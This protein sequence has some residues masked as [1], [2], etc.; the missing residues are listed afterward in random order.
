MSKYWFFLSYAR[1]NDL[2]SGR[3]GD[4]KDRRLIQRFYQDLVREMISRGLASIPRT[5]TEVGFFDQGGIEPGDIWDETLAKALRTSRVLV[6]LYSRGYFESEYCGKEFQVF[7]SRVRDYSITRN[8]THLPLIIPVLWHRPDKFPSLPACTSDI[9]YAHDEFGSVYAVE[10]L[11]YI[12]RLQKCK[13]NYEEFLIRFT[14]KLIAI[15]EEHTMPILAECPPLRTIQSAFHAPTPVSQAV[16]MPN[17]AQ[18]EEDD[19]RELENT[20]PGVVHFVFAAAS[21]QELRQ[22]RTKLEAYTE[23]G[24]RYWKPYVPD[25]DK[26]VGFITQQ[27]LIDME[28]QQEVL[29]FSRK[30]TDQILRADVQAAIIEIQRKLAER[31]NLL[32]PVPQNDAGFTLIPQI[33]GPGGTQ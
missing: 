21:S 22:V 30:L 18:G 19:E 14:D 8:A 12:M 16:I 5:E 25:V 1:R 3:I 15:A 32:R 27:A 24:G 2:R 28:L 10:G 20:G 23:W 11:E 6:C 33:T 13:D 17:G 26:Q 29:P 4:S 9:Q 31:A 7:Q